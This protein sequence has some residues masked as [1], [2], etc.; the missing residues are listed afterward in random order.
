MQFTKLIRSIKRHWQR[1]SLILGMVLLALSLMVVTM[2]LVFRIGRTTRAP[3]VTN[4]NV[5]P[6]AP[7]P[8][9]RP[10][11]GYVAVVIDNH[12]DSRPPSGLRNAS[13]VIEAPVEGTFTRFLAL[14][15]PGNMPEEVGPVRSIRPYFLDWILGFQSVLFM[16]F[17]GSPEALTRI[18]NTPALR[19]I[20]ADG[21]SNAGSAYWRDERRR[22]PHNAYTSKIDAEKIIA[23]RNTNLPTE[24]GWLFLPGLETVSGPYIQ[25]NHIFFYDRAGSA[26]WGF[27]PQRNVYARVNLGAAPL[28]DR[29][30]EPIET[31]NIIVMNTDVKTIDAIG[32]KRIR[33]TGEGT[34][35]VFRNGEEVVATW[36][37]QT[38]DALP[39]FYDEKDAEVVLAEG[40]V[41]I[42]VVPSSP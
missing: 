33:T 35:R 22:M 2:I 39:R 16:H 24:N 37:R 21:M 8:A 25:P 26:V 17:G 13:V 34:A 28:V 14:F 7:I 36:R 32:R 1:T 42:T 23:A 10:L 29:A 12:P 11:P 4:V 5:E 31:K 19:A 18:A 6:V 30:G 38:L 41:W 15:E 40:S 3:V 9:S 20:D 27:I